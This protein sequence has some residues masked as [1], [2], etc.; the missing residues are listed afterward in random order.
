MECNPTPSTLL[1][2][3]LF[4]SLRWRRTYFIFS[5][6]YSAVPL[7]LGAI[8]GMDHSPPQN[9]NPLANAGFDPHRRYLQ[10]SPTR[11]PQ[12]GAAAPLPSPTR[13]GR[14]AHDVI[15]RNSASGSKQH[16]HDDRKSWESTTSARSVED[17][18]QLASLAKMRVMADR[19]QEDVAAGNNSQRTCICFF[20]SRKPF[21]VDSFVR[22]YMWHPNV[23]CD[24]YLPEYAATVAYIIILLPPEVY[25]YILR[26][27]YCIVISFSTFVCFFFIVFFL[28]KLPTNVMTCACMPDGDVA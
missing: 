4:P 28:K 26:S 8:Q 18:A 9:R 3:F 10:E 27:I 25:Y 12:A 20:R 17:S 5:V 14:E 16:G 13:I 15:R 11:A 22:T 2:F 21:H 6:S 7:A 23:P 19:Q 24:A 1:F